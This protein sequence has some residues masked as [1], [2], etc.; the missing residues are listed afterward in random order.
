MFPVLSSVEPV[1]RAKE[2]S[3][4]PVSKAKEEEVSDRDDFMLY[5]MQ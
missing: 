2:V 4:E 1:S 3:L 5:L